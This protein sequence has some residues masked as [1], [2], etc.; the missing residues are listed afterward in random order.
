MSHLFI[1]IVDITMSSLYRDTKD[2]NII[3]MMDENKQINGL[4]INLE[5]IQPRAFDV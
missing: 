2:G 3:G 5:Y 4:E 1:P